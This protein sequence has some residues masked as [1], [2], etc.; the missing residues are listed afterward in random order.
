M[1]SNVQAACDMINFNVLVPLFLAMNSYTD[2]LTTGTIFSL[3]K[4]I[5]TKLKM[6]ACI[7]SFH[8]YIRT[9]AHLMTV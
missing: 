5:K 1:H 7:I 9:L 2:I 4:I 6:A 8:N 3:T